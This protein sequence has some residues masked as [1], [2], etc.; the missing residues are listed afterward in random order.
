MTIIAIQDYLYNKRK[1]LL[2]K[3]GLARKIYHYPLIGSNDKI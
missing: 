3:V 1:L 2:H